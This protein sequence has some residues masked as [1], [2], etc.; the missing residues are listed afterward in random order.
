MIVLGVDPSGEFDKGKGT[1]GLAIVDDS[2]G[3]PLLI[4]HVVV[5]ASDHETSMKYWEAVY[6]K[7]ASLTMLYTID[8]VV[9]EDYILYGSSAKAQI[10]SGMETSKL[11]GMLTFNL[12]MQHGIKVYLNIAANVKNRWTNEILEHEQIIVM[13]KG[14]AW[15]GQNRPINPHALDAVRH[16]THGIFFLVKKGKFIK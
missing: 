3:K 1:T 14:R 7:I 13:H 12:I 8:D 15:D 9:I 2:E 4:H 10:N 11:I 16:A 6:I 5:K